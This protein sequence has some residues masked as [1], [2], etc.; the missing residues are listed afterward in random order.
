MNAFALNV[1][2]NAASVRK[3]SWPVLRQVLAESTER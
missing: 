1:M 2:M 3:Q